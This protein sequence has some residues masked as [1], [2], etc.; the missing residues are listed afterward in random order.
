MLQSAKAWAQNYRLLRNLITHSH[1]Q[2]YSIGV[3]NNFILFYCLSLSICR[4]L[5][6]DSSIAKIGAVPLIR[7]MITQGKI[8]QYA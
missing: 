2:P 8:F 4:S 6:V 1:C 7:D 5:I 3:C